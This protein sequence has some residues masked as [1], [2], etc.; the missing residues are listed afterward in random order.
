MPINEMKV[1]YTKKKN[2][3]KA[4]RL[5]F[6]AVEYCGLIINKI[7]DKIM[8]IKI[9][10]SSILALPITVSYLGPRK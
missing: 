1:I 4:P 9:K 2:N 3:A 7:G 6:T 10:I 8:D 5:R